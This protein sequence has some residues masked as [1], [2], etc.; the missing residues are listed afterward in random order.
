MVKKEL[1]RNGFGMEMCRAVL[2]FAAENGIS[3]ATVRIPEGNAAS[4]KL[5]EALQ[6]ELDVEILSCKE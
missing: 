5:A 6:R 4:R 1:R 2:V 3:R